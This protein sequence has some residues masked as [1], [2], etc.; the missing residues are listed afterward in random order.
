MP[1][2]TLTLLKGRTRIQKTEILDS[3]HD[4]LVKCGIPQTDR[5]QRVIELNAEDFV[6]DRNYPEMKIPRSDDFILIEIL[7]SVGRSVKVKKEI[8]KNLISNLSDHSKIDPRDIMIVFKETQ[9]ENWS[10]ESG[11]QIHV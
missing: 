2:V 3:I 8:L 10:F 11:V 4:A 5:F 9:W 7:L 1:L 6:F